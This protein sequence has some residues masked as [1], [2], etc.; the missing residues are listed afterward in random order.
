VEYFSP[1]REHGAAM[2][3]DTSAAENASAQTIASYAGTSL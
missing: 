2:Y 1:K 3:A